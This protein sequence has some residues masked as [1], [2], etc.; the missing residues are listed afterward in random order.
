[1]GEAMTTAF[2]AIKT[3]ILGGITA[4]APIAIGIMGAFLAWRYGS[5]FFK[6]LSK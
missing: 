6:G 4:V 5:K 2:T 3:D 1:M